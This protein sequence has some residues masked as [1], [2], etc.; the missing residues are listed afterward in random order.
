MYSCHSVFT[1]QFIFRTVLVR[2]RI[3]LKSLESVS[4][5]YRPKNNIIFVPFNDITFSFLIPYTLNAFIDVVGLWAPV[6]T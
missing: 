4:K 5:T 3:S 1:D 2:I 6:I